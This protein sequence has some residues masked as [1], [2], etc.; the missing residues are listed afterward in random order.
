MTIYRDNGKGGRDAI[1]VTPGDDGTFELD[2]KKIGYGSD[3]KFY[4]LTGKGEGWQF[5]A[6]KNGWFQHDEPAQS[7]VQEHPD[8]AYNG[9]VAKDSWEAVHTTTDNKGVV[10]NGANQIQWDQSA[11]PR[12]YKRALRDERRYDYL[13]RRA[14][15]RQDYRNGK[16]TW[17]KMREFNKGIWKQ[18]YG[19]QPEGRQNQ[20]E[21]DNAR[22][23]AYKAKYRAEGAKAA[24]TRNAAVSQAGPTQFPA[25]TTVTNDNQNSQSTIQQST[26]AVRPFDENAPTFRFGGKLS[27]FDYLQM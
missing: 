18:T 10:Y 22:A 7:W 13:A 19:T 3:G 14:A 26:S 4:E 21:A 9:T 6:S 20:L 11:N 23:K 24:Q 5:D 12:D 8:L 27:Y 2:G 17:A 1:N 25:Q 16:L 15:N